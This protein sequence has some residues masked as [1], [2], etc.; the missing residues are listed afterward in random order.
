M[1]LELHWGTNYPKKLIEIV[2]S[3]CFKAVLWTLA[4]DPRGETWR[5]KQHVRLLFNFIPLCFWKRK[6]N[7]LR[8][9]T[10][11]SSLYLALISAAVWSHL[12]SLHKPGQG[13]QTRALAT[14]PGRKKEIAASDN[15]PDAAPSAEPS[16][17]SAAHTSV[18]CPAFLFRHPIIRLSI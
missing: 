10:P 2:K 1:L 6:K 12:S 11:F 15:R 14:S 5:G 13:E 9:K 18:S 8:G 7:W 17:R 3:D 4:F 16:Y